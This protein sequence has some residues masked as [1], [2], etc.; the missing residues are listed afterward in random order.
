VLIRRR[1][2]DLLAAVLLLM[3]AAA[4]ATHVWS[5]ADWGRQ[6]AAR[7]IA[8]DGGAIQHVACVASSARRSS[9][10]NAALVSGIVRALPVRARVTILTN[11]RAAF[12]VAQNPDPQRVEF[13][14]LPSEAAFT[15]W[16]QDPF[17]VLQR[18]DGGELLASRDFDRV[19][20]RLIAQRLAEHLSW[21][22]RVSHFKFEGG[23]I[24]VG[25]RHVFIGANTIL[26]NAEE[27]SLSPQRVAK[28]LAAELGRPPLVVGPAP[29]PVGH[30][31]MML[32]PLDDR[33]LMLADPGWGADL[34]EEQLRSAPGD[35]E[36]FERSCQQQ[37]FGDPAIRRLRDREG[38]VVTAPDLVGRTPAAVQASRDI[39]RQLDDL[40]QELARWGYRVHRVPFLNPPMEKTPAATRAAA[41]PAANDASESERDSRPVY[42][43]L[44]YN[45]VL[46][47]RI[48]D[49]RT[50]W[51][52][53]YGWPALDDAAV[54]AWTGVGYQVIPVEGFSTS[55]MYGGSLRCCV[56]VLKR[57]GPSSTDAGGGDD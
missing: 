7:A 6:P 57:A 16:P 24:V 19:D 26:G 9:M 47:E 28:E 53:Q 3:G 37:F 48:A 34:A 11:D 12:V 14:D 39:A 36:A 45:N 13:L 8:D 31:D 33:T 32:T 1:V 2:T 52:P 41:P 38:K 25:Y 50:V 5:R 49:E 46:L 27:L 40:A 54:E 17:L 42:P 35:V 18:R 4:I 10:R 15:I 30:L 56:K 43:C 51:L 29:Q 55:A 23:N 22:L 20:D 21:P 44:T